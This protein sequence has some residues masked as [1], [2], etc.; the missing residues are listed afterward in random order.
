MDKQIKSDDI[1][2]KTVDREDA[3]SSFTVEEERSIEKKINEASKA[4]ADEYEKKNA[5]LRADIE[6]IRRNAQKEVQFKVDQAMIRSL[7]EFLSV[8]DDYQRALEHAKSFD[9]NDLLMG[10]TITYER[11]LAIFKKLGVTEIKADGEFNPELHEAVSA[12]KSDEKESGI[13]AEV[14]EKGYFY[15][16]KVLRPAKVIVVE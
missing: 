9:N 11:F 16:N 8:L 1:V 7:S 13:I 3:E 6:N 4:I 15:K 5:Y 10:L 2:K 14:L 12:V